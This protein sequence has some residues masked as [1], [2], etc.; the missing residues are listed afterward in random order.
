MESADC[1]CTSFDAIR[2]DKRH[3]SLG[4][5]ILLLDVLRKQRPHWLGQSQ[6]SCGGKSFASRPLLR[7]RQRCSPVCMAPFSSC[8]ANKSCICASDTPSHSA[9]NCRR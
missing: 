5:A 6:R 2:S 4:F 3:A 1:T 7:S 9:A 8:N